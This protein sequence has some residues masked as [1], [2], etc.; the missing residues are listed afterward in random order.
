MFA[1]STARGLQCVMTNP[2]RFGVLWLVLLLAGGT[3]RAAGPLS[4]ADNHM[5]YGLG[6]ASCGAWSETNNNALHVAFQQWL[7]GFV[8]GVEYSRSMLE[9]MAA[10]THIGTNEKAVAAQ[11][12]AAV[13]VGILMLNPTDPK[14]L[15]AWMDQYC[16]SNPLKPVHV[17]AE[18]LVLELNVKPVIP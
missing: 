7:T 15:S 3:A 14:G 8:S 17:G 6:S 4:E 11:Q 5:V 9:L 2:L 10:I 1:I 13:Y 12:S 18:A 16:A